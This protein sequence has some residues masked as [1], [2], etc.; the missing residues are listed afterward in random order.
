MP[1]DMKRVI[2]E[3]LAKMVEKTEVDKI[4]A[5]ALIRECHISRQTFYYHFKDLMDVFQWSVRQAT[6]ELVKQSLEAEDTHTALQEFIRFSADHYGVMKKLLESHN[7]AQLEK[8]LIEAVG[9]YLWEVAR[10]KRLISSGDPEELEIA[11]QFITYGLVGVL[12]SR[13]GDPRLDQDKLAKQLEPL[14][15]NQRLFLERQS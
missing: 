12:L 3:T 2:A 1:V 15:I 6:Q 5:T 10:H 14:L 7:R 11:L 4:T 9:T 8:L 13:C